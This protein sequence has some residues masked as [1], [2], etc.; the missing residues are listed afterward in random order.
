MVIRNIEKS[1]LPL[2][3]KLAKDESVKTM[4]DICFEHSKICFS[5]EGDVLC[6]IALREHSLMDFF[7]GNIPK[8]ENLD[9]DAEEGEEWWIKE[10]IESYVGKHYEVVA[11]YLKN[12]YY[13]SIYSNLLY[14]VEFEEWKP[15]IGILWSV[16]DLPIS[17]N[18]YHFNNT[19][20]LDIPM[21]D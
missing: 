2:V 17:N 19:V 10:D 7:N 6:F 8:D 16:K 5:D 4:D 18:F 3:A 9:D 20:W 21:I 14:S 11:T 12:S 13:S 15:Q 1:D